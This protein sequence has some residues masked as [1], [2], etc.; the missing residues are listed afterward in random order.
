MRLPLLAALAL[1]TMAAADVEPDQ[2]G[3]ISQT[4]TQDNIHQTICMKRW[5]K[6]ARPS[7]NVTE[8]LKYRL[9]KHHPGADP[10]QFELDH[11][12]PIEDGGCP[13]C[14]ENLWLEPWR[15][16]THHKC[17]PN[18]MM[19]AACKDKLENL[20]H[21]QICSGQMTLA[22]GQAVFLG[23]WIANYKILIQ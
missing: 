2:P 13:D 7:V 6:R 18:V 14:V 17:V 15:D 22:Q 3:A 12:V 16:P 21:R 9:L 11:R 5:S 4:V 20:V 1:I 23:D 10:R 8:P 19:D